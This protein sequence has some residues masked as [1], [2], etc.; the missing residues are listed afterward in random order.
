MIWKENIVVVGKE[1]ISILP[2]FGMFFNQMKVGTLSNNPYI[3]FSGIS[4]SK[5]D[6]KEYCSAKD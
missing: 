3:V 5:I 4:S 2:I 1:E 6:S